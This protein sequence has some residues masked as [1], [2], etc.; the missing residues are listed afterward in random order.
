MSLSAI[1]PPSKPRQFSTSQI[2]HFYFAHIGHYHFAV[3]AE[4]KRQIS[5]ST[6]Y[7]ALSIFREYNISVIC[8]DDTK[9]SQ[10]EELSEFEFIER[11]FPKDFSLDISQENKYFQ[12]PIGLA[13]SCR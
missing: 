1:L 3:T 2:G 10:F 4:T 12:M 5:K 6:Y 7:K 11:G 8:S 13:V 9:N